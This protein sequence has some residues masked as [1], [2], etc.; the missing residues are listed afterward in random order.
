MLFFHGSTTPVGLSLFVVKVSRSHSDT[1]HSVGLIG[2][3]QRPLRDNIQ[4]SRLTSLPLAGFEPAIPASEQ[5]Q[6][7]AYYLHTLKAVPWLR[8][9]AARL[10][11]R[12]PGFDPGSVHVE[13]VVDKVALGQ[14][15]PRVPLS[16]S[17]H[18]CSITR[19]R[20]KIIIIIFII[21]LHNKLQG[22]GASVASAA[23]PFTATAFKKF[24]IISA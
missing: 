23:G 16:I 21:G 6:G 1:P 14:V 3:S 9:L 7:S 24:C 12:R 2:P 4:R 20:T 18:R 8:R 17:F 19:K 11:P 13:F 10:P 22:C 5:P 15:F